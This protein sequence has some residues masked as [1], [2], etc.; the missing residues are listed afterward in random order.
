MATMPKKRCSVGQGLDSEL[1]P[2]RFPLKTR[3]VW[4]S[5]RDTKMLL[6]CLDR[7]FN[8]AVQTPLRRYFILLQSRYT[9]AGNDDIGRCLTTSPARIWPVNR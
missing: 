3:D 4:P 5:N 7:R 8:L 9:G 2:Y 6:C 1:K